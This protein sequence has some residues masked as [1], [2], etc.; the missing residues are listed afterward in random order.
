MELR[1]SEERLRQQQQSDAAQRENVLVKRL[2]VKEQQLQEYM[3]RVWRRARQTDGGCW[4]DGERARIDWGR[5][6]DGDIATWQ[7]YFGF[8][9]T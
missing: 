4:V 6:T 8:Y 2:T 1:E 7:F 3:V 9:F 5:W